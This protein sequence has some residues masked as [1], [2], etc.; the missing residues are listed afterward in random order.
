MKIYKIPVT[1][2]VIATMEIDAESLEDAILKAEDA[3]LPT[4]PDYLDGSF[5]VDHAWV[6]SIF[7]VQ[8]GVVP[9]PAALR[10]DK[11]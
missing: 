1:W 8:I 4:D 2:S 3:S 11:K 6:R 10:L 7:L 9:V 5:E